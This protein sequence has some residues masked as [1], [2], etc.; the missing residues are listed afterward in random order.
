MKLRDLAERLDCR[1]EGDGDVDIH[2]VAGIQ[3]AESGD[4]TFLAN[5]KY[6]KSLRATRASA[7]ILK[8]DAPAAPCAMLRAKDPYLAFARAVGLFAPAWRPSPG[9]HSL[10]ALAAGAQL[11]AEVSVG[12][13][14]AVGE[15]AAI[16]DRTFPGDGEWAAHGGSGT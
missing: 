1:L 5:P 10:A 16:G 3:A 13:F 15:G 2:R 9:I 14:V 12:A 7:V 4:I 6:E 11:G 8:D